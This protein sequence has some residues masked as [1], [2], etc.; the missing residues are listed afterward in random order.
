MAEIAKISYTHDALIDAVIANPAS[1]QKD[2][3]RLFGYTESWISQIM[4]SDSFKVRLEARRKVVIDPILIQNI[5]ERMEGVANQALAVIAEKLEANG[6]AD[7]AT[8][9][10]EITTRALGY[11]ARD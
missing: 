1:K 9:A 6:S 10:L 11:G 5:E 2:L 4:S 8:R 7:L 3:A